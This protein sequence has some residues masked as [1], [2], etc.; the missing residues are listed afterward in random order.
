MKEDKVTNK[1]TYD[2]YT[3][4]KVIRINRALFIKTRNIISGEIFWFIGVETFFDF[5]T[6]IKRVLAEDVKYPN[7]YFQ[8]IFKD[9][10][11]FK[12]RTEEKVK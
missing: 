5:N 8:N 7:S 3:V 10:A 12:I 6:N 11:N 2:N 9:N 1:I 4:L